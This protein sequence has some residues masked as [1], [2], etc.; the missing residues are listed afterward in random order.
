MK[1]LHIYTAGKLFTKF[2]ID[3]ALV[4]DTAASKFDVFTSD[5]YYSRV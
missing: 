1:L 5:W 2:L 3:M 4:I